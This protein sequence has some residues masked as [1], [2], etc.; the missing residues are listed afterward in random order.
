MVGGELRAKLGMF[1]SLAEFDQLTAELDADQ[2][3]PGAPAEGQRGRTGIQRQVALP[4]GWL[5]DREIDAV[6]ATMIRAAELSVSG[7]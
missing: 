3:H 5:A 2:P 6:T 4:E 1:T 7:G